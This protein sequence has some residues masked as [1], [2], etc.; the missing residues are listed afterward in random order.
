M[1]IRIVIFLWHLSLQTESGVSLLFHSQTTL[2]LSFNYSSFN[3]TTPPSRLLSLLSLIME[4]EGTQKSDAVGGKPTATVS[5][6]VANA[7][8]RVFSS[9]DSDAAV[10]KT[11]AATDVMEKV[12]SSPDLC[13]R[14]AICLESSDMMRCKKISL[15]MLHCVL[16]HSLIGEGCA[17][18]DCRDFMCFDCCFPLRT[19]Y[20]CI[21]SSCGRNDCRKLDYCTD[22][23][24]KTAICT[25]CELF[26]KCDECTIVKCEQYCVSECAGG[27]HEL[28]G[29]E[30]PKFICS[31]PDCGFECAECNDRFCHECAGSDGRCYYCV[32]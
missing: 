11:L 20:N 31:E 6:A 12:F 25:L 21:E 22:P 10:V 24:C 27:W 1:K 32:E 16:C 2:R 8:K 7:E 23:D 5:T 19:C 29:D 28:H 13:A 9:S 14:V 3:Q 4:A 26:K 18:N 17:C 15:L 30:E